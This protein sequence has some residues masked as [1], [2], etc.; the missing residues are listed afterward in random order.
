MCV[1]VCV[2]VCGKK[3]K[4]YNKKS[5]TTNILPLL[6]CVDEM[7]IAINKCINAKYLIR[8]VNFSS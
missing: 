8:E 5:I 7:N 3:N 6:W 2:C 4:K 1:C